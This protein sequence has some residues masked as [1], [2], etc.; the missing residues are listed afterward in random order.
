MTDAICLGTGLIAH[1]VNKG[2]SDDKI[3]HYYT[4]YFGEKAVSY[5]VNKTNWPRYI[6]K[7]IPFIVMI[8]A[9]TI[10]EMLD[11]EFKINDIGATATGSTFAVVSYKVTLNKVRERS[12][13]KTAYNADCK[14]YCY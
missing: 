11:K 1:Y 13:Q 7:T 12:K 2:S 6:K 14:C 8:S 5:F 9:A 3:L 4:G 10:K